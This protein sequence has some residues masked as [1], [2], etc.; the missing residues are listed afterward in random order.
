MD[1]RMRAE[2]A[3]DPERGNKAL[4]NGPFREPAAGYAYL[5]YLAGQS[6]FNGKSK[7][8]RQ[9]AKVKRPAPV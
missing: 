2:I 6:S 4:G 9:M 5:D 7:G 8:K 1:L 3:F